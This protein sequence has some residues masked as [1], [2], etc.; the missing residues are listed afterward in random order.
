MLSRS[1]HRISLTYLRGLD[2]DVQRRFTASL[3]DHEKI[4][5]LSNWWFIGRPEQLMPYGDHWSHWLYL[6]GRGAGKTRTG[7]ELAREMVRRGYRRLG[8][9][10]PTSADARDVMIEGESGVLNVCTDND[11]TYR[12]AIMARPI[13][14]SSKRRLVWQNGATAHLYSADE[15]ERLRGPQHEFIWADEL[16]SWRYPETWD[17]AMFG[18][19][20]GQHP[21]AFIS[22]TPKPVLLLKQLLSDKNC[23]TTRGTTY[24]NRSNLAKQFFAQ[25]VTKYE[26]TRLG[27]QELSGELLLE[28]ENA[29]WNRE[30]L[31]SLRVTA[32]QLPEL[33][34]VVVAVDPAISANKASDETGIVVVGVGVDN[35]GYVIA[36]YSGKFTPA[37]WASRVN[38]AY[39]AYRA[40]CVVAEG[41]QGG[42]MV[43]SVI[44]GANSAMPVRLVHASSGKYARAQP[45]AA[46]FERRICHIVG[47]LAP[48]EDQL[49]TWEPQG[50]TGSPDRLDA[51]VWGLTDCMLG[52]GEFGEGR[53]SGAY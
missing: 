40:N 3:T 13:Y 47:T 36:D 21:R 11:T 1:G 38:R 48:L 44:K 12:G 45:V 20:L 15:P 28:A 39:T 49:C 4:E 35:H 29:L 46:L 52:R 26:G 14:E 22:T 5:L 37:G 17:L 43:R 24:D 50:N 18:L 9:I 53:L 30:M 19:R 25:I 7:A 33:K 6:A 27:R 34:Y 16:A 8:L 42:D 23:I 41:N 31:D 32:E 10:A 51:M 2:K